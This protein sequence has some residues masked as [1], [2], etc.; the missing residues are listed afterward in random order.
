MKKEILIFFAIVLLAAVALFL[1]G[2][3]AQPPPASDPGPN[4]T[5]DEFSQILENQTTIA[6]VM[7]FE[8]EDYKNQFVANCS[9]GLARSLGELGK[10][11]KNYAIQD[12]YCV[13]PLLANV[14]LQDCLQEIGKTYYFEVRY[15]GSSTKFYEKKTVIYVDENFGS[16]CRIASN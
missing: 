13:T 5:M 3:Q 16:E 1:M 12:G 6:N 11:V 7:Y 4:I 14:T 8:K 10:T 15:G 2:K 9:I